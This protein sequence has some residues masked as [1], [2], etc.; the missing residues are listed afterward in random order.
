MAVK[1]KK[2]KKRIV[3]IVLC[4]VALIVIGWWGFC[5]YVYND[6]FDIRA[7]SYA[8]LMLRVEDFD[9]LECAEYS[10]PSDRGQMLSGYLYRS[11]E[12]QHGIVIIK[13]ARKT[14]ADKVALWM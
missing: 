3:L 5:V 7:E 2:S 1:K 13:T 9:G 12:N 10:F 8:P 6:S 14:L 4:I 11:G